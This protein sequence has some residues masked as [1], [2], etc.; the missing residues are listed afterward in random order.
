MSAPAL[1]R[2]N[3]VYHKKSHKKF[4]TYFKKKFL[5]KGELTSKIQLWLKMKLM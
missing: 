3:T 4:G 5:L 2:V 1:F